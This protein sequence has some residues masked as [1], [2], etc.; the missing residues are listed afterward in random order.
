MT[1]T[2][3][4][5][6]QPDPAPELTQKQK[7]AKHAADLAARQRAMMIVEPEMTQLPKAKPLPDGYGLYLAAKYASEHPEE[8]QESLPFLDSLV[9]TEIAADSSS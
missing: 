6:E 8:T 1:I 3:A 2:E 5:P 7:A 4:Q 9:D